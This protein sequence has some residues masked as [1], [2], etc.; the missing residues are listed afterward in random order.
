MLSPFKFKPAA[1]YILFIFCL[2][3]VYKHQPP[4]YVIESVLVQ[5]ERVKY[6]VPGDV[7]YFYDVNKT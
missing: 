6:V 5:I 4:F 7:R 3:F 2:E 1:V